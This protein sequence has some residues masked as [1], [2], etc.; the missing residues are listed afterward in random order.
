[1]LEAVN[2]ERNVDENDDGDEV[3]VWEVDIGDDVRVVCE[4]VGEGGVGLKRR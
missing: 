4:G 3:V 1:M 2:K